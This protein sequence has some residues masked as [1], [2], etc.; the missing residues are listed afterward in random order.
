M[1]IDPLRTV[2]G[3]LF[4]LV[5]SACSQSQEPKPT[6]VP[7]LSS[8][9]LTQ[10][11][12]AIEDFT[13]S[14]LANLSVSSAMSEDTEIEGAGSVNSVHVTQTHFFEAEPEAE[15]SMQAFV[16]R[17]RILFGDSPLPDSDDEELQVAHSVLGGAE[18][19][20]EGSFRAPSPNNGS[21]GGH[22]L[23]GSGSD[24]DHGLELGAGDTRSST[25]GTSESALTDGPAALVNAPL[26][27]LGLR[28]F[29]G[30]SPFLPGIGTPVSDDEGAQFARSD[31][32]GA[33]LE[34][35]FDRSSPVDG[36][37]GDESHGEHRESTLDDAL[38]LE[39][40]A[41]GTP[42]STPDTSKSVLTERTAAT[43]QAAVV[44][45]DG[46]VM[47]ASAPST[48]NRGRDSRSLPFLSPKRLVFKLL[49]SS[50]G[51][52]EDLGGGRL[53]LPGFA[54]LVDGREVGFSEGG[55]AL[56]SCGWEGPN[57][58]GLGDEAGSAVSSA[59]AGLESIL[60]RVASATDSIPE[61]VA[62]G[63]KE[64]G[65]VEIGELQEALD[66]RGEA[67][68]LSTVWGWPR[69]SIRVFP[70]EMVVRIPGRRS[71]PLPEG[72]DE[73][74]RV[75]PILECLSVSPLV[76]SEI[77][78][79]AAGSAAVEAVGGG[80]SA[81]SLDR[82][83]YHEK[84]LPPVPRFRRSS[85]PE[86]SRSKGVVRENLRL[87]GGGSQGD[88]EQRGLSSPWLS[89][90]KMPGQRT[91][92]ASLCSLVCRS[93][94]SL[95]QAADRSAGAGGGGGGQLSAELGAPLRVTPVSSDHPEYRRLAPGFRALGKM[96]EVPRNFDFF[97]EGG[98]AI[99]GALG[100]GA[101]T[102]KE[103]QV[104][105]AGLGGY[106][107]D[108]IDLASVAQIA[109]SEELLAELKGK[110][111]WD[112]HGNAYHFTE[113]NQDYLFRW[114]HRTEKHLVRCIFY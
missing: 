90:S 91:R 113:R 61:G 49:P 69:R 24:D 104:F 52:E 82:S 81:P 26:T 97:P 67:S 66:A 93:S 64:P 111:F 34:W 33:G 23:L 43:A 73:V 15:E 13:A 75:S 57:S 101:M 85:L 60:G 107:P 59:E 7:T 86:F 71:S 20:G 36:F 22:L 79:L 103:A 50:E 55:R 9:P 35:S 94:V 99:W 65:G 37:F 105:C 31:L 63:R 19:G 51:P 54:T 1:R 30:G 58:V 3:L 95:A 114:P 87:S 110:S 76:H 18:W 72:S 70:A 106:L 109:H 38:E 102:F 5:S 14:G 40:A 42:S 32:D 80:S 77:G 78:A 44:Y 41:A 8:T 25:P 84:R 4:A 56:Y 11:S 29:V 46:G 10:E 83:P 89:V 98:T 100:P 108:T 48:P 88:F 17:L 112:S 96:Y 12:Q 16:S 68:G 47:V 28:D 39:L 6:Q 53:A 92:R 21:F 74:S 62:P 45:L 27:P 2:L